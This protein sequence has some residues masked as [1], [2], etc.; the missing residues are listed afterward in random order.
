MRML[1]EEEANLILCKLGVPTDASHID[2]RRSVPCYICTTLC[3]KAKEGGADEVDRECIHAVHSRPV[4]ERVALE[5]RTPKFLCVCMFRCTQIV[6]KRR[7]FAR[8]A[9]T[10]AYMRGLNRAPK[11]LSMGE[12]MR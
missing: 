6:Q 4:V 9:R 8:L 3:K 7:C 11:I 2:N 5:E 1:R 12:L 10:S